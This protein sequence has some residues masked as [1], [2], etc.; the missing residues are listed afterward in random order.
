MGDKLDPWFAAIEPPHVALVESILR[1]FMTELEA[2]E[3]DYQHGEAQQLL[4]QLFVQQK[5]FDRF[6]GLAA[7][8]GSRA[9]EP[10]L[11]LAAAAWK[12]KRRELALAVFTAAD[13]PGFH[14]DY[15]R[16]ECQAMTGQL[17][18]AK[19]HLGIVR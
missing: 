10:I 1:E 11:Q 4:A 3:F 2:H 12:A 8:M 6:V 16:Q 17:P 15:L 18:P 9:W 14:R 5:L 19:R 7:Q 13:Q